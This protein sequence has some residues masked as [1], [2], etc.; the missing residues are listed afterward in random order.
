[1][2]VISL[3]VSELYS[4]LTI[5]C[6]FI[7]FH[8]RYRNSLIHKYTTT[9]S[10]TMNYTSYFQ[11]L[12]FNWYRVTF[13]YLGDKAIMNKQNIISQTGFGMNTGATAHEKLEWNLK[14]FQWAKSRFYVSSQPPP[15]SP[16][17]VLPPKKHIPYTC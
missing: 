3:L 8:I 14:C 1:M 5:A 4:M 13:M 2:L 12:F 7:T 6:A 9:P 17:P 10:N 15:A 16:K 11:Y